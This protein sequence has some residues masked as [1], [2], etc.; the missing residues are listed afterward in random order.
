MPASLK[1]PPPTK[2]EFL[3]RHP[4]DS[5]KVIAY[6]WYGP[7]GYYAVLFVGGERK[8][9]RES[10]SATRREAQRAVVGWAIEL[11]FFSLSD[12]DDVTDALDTLRIDQL[13]R[14][15]RT[16]ADLVRSFKE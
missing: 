14:R 12:I 11:G 7:L 16:L 6:G 4:T 3:L 13:P 5:T 15:M 10:K 8:D 2:R 9:G 1:P